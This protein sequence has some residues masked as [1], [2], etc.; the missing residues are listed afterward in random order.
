[1]NRNHLKC[2]AAG[3]MAL[4]YTVPANALESSV[5]YAGFLL[6]GNIASTS[7]SDGDTRP[8][9]GLTLGG[10]ISP[11]FG[12]GFYGGFSGQRSSGTFLGL[13]SG[14]STSMTILAGQLNFFAGPLH[15]GAEAG[16]AISSWS[17]NIS[18]VHA[19]DSTTDFVYGPQGGVD[20]QLVPNLSLGAELHYLITT[21]D[22]GVNNLQA[23]AALKVWM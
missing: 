11:E 4:A 6:G 21:A 2:M 8:N 9:I 18:S 22:S 15:L 13:P 7:G 23:L 3:L 19:G 12:L 10:K 14:T 16:A 20:F 5:G 1:M 17:G